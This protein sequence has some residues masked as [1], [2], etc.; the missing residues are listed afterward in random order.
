[1]TPAPDRL[2]AL[3]RNYMGWN[4]PEQ[5]LSEGPGRLIAQVMEIGTWEDAHALLKAVGE[6]AFREVLAAPPP[7]ILS[8][9][10]WTFWHHRLRLGA[11]TRPTPKRLDALRA[12]PDAGR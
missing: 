11:P 8:E 5:S 6:D 2:H 3:A 9:K 12:L 7:G 4:A 1:M 10:S